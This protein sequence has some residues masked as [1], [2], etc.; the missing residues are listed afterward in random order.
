MSRYQ[1]GKTNLDLPEKETVSG[2]GIS[3]A[4]CKSAHRPR[5]I[6]MPASHHAI[7][8]QAGCP[9]CRSTNSVKALKALAEKNDLFCVEWDVKPQLSQML[10][11]HSQHNFKASIMQVV[12]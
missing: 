10:L 8:L 1:K 3:C 5:Q 4:I 2:S 7:F 11:A 12:I 6:T 9:S